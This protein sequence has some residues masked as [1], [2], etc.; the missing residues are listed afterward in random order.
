[1]VET[2]RLSMSLAEEMALE[3]VMDVRESMAM[4]QLPLTYIEH[5]ITA[6]EKS[7]IQNDQIMAKLTLLLL[8]MGTGMAADT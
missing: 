7:C 1:M 6:L 3:L 2:L 4:D 8:P 5:Y